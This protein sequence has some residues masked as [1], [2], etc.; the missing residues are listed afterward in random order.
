PHRR[1]TSRASGARVPAPRPRTTR[2]ALSCC[3]R[4]GVDD[5]DI[6]VARGHAAVRDRVRL[7]RLT[8]AVVER[9]ADPVGARAADQIHRVPELRRSKLIRHV[10]EHLADLAIHDLVEYL[11][12]ELCVVSL[13]V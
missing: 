1:R 8:L 6:P 10:A 12:A 3:G 11:P 2:S 5:G 4:S 7:A 9:A 13:L